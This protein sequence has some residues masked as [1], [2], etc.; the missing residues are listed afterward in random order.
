[1]KHQYRKAFSSLVEAEETAKA[2]FT[3]PGIDKLGFPEVS[4][5]HED[6]EYYVYVVLQGEHDP[7]DVLEA[8]GYERVS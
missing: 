7:K 1:M 4:T 6:G 8:T 2:F 5:S 3:Y